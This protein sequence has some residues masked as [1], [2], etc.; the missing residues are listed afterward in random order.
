MSLLRKSGISALAITSAGT[1]ALWNSRVGLA[2]IHEAS[3]YDKELLK[4]LPSR[5]SLVD[6]L[7]KE[8]QFDVLV[9]GGGSAGAG[10]ALD[11][12]TRGLKT[13]MVEYGDYCCGTSSKS[14]KLLHG[15]VKY[16][17]TALKEF[18]YEQYKI[19]QE[20]LN[21]RIN[22]MKAAPFLSHSFPVLVPTYKWWQSIYY[23]GG[24]KV[25]DLLAGKGI[26]KP[27]K[28]I[29]KEEAL[30][31]C[32]T[33]KKEGLR[34]AMLYYDGQ[35]ND[36]RL[37]IVVALTAIRYGAKCVNYTE[38]IG[39][40]KDSNGKVNGAVVKDHISGETYNIRA[41][42]VVNA[43]G[44]FNDHIRKMADEKQ[45]PM[46]Y[47]SSGI[48]FTVAK[49]FCPGN[50][51]LINPK[52]SDGRVIFAFP[53]EDVTI[54]GCTDDPAEATHSPSVSEKEI[55]YIM[56]EMNKAFAKEYQIKREDIVSVWSGIRGLVWDPRKKD[57]LTLHRGH[58]VD[59]GPTGLVTIAGGKLTTFRHMAEETMDKVVEVNKLE[60]ATSC[61]TR[62][63]MFE[64]GHN[65]NPMLYRTIAREYGLEEQV[66]THLCET[67]GDK[68][69]EV[70]KLCKST[71][72]KFPAIGHRLHPDFPFLEAE[73]RYAVKEYARIPA[74]ILARRTRLSLL[75]A[76]A[77]KQVLPRVVA[78][79]AEELGWNPC[80]Q[81]KQ[82]D[83]GLEF[84]K[85]EMGVF[86]LGKAKGDVKKLNEAEKSEIAAKFR[87]VDK[88]G[89]GNFTGED[90]KEFLNEQKKSQNVHKDILDDVI[91]EANNGNRYITLEELQKIYLD[92]KNGSFKGRRLI[93]HLGNINKCESEM[94][95]N[96]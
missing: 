21:E 32:P 37:V 55:N 28:F 48:H 1:F 36:A 90:L 73:V 50:T 29:S 16:L 96:K 22:V 54:V 51:G 77:A 10:V 76:R 18:H 13:A 95:P 65:W 47:G 39:L 61:V 49:Y 87:R 20:G 41:K 78:I 74:D 44:P 92:N 19:V 6:S 60:D 42:V 84:L 75:D 79:M 9:I 3:K 70:L 52:S 64:G 85:V 57:H 15:G 66:A 35:Q 53:W 82:Y 40:L 46:I 43:T 31:I 68:V 12:Q 93:D 83:A 91:L 58:V 17:E 71:G 63:M 89:R 5:E 72:K 34:G 7:K 67:Y 62:G 80:E 69:Y 81:K 33:I 45:K 30:E 56:D 86:N 59:V 38:C 25:Y 94:K 88:D 27:S 11:A 4:D 14:S 26:L 23:W 8:K 24:V 2:K